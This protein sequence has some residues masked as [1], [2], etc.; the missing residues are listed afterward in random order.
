MH[1]QP[2]NI[3]GILKL[4]DA[5]GIGDDNDVGTDDGTPENS[6]ASLKMGGNIR[7]NDP[8]VTVQAI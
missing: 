2:N 7:R 8:I 6:V 4:D 1:Y 5:R 3:T